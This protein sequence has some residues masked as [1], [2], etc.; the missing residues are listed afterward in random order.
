MNEVAVYYDNRTG[1]GLYYQLDDDDDS[2]FAFEEGVDGKLR[3]YSVLA[4][5]LI[6]VGIPRKLYYG[7]VRE[8]DPD[9]PQDDD[10]ILGLI[11]LD[12]DGEAENRSQSGGGILAARIGVA[13]LTPEEYLEVVQGEAKTITFIVEAKGRFLQAV[14]DEITVK[15]QDVKKVTQTV[16]DDQIERVTQELDIQVFRANI[17]AVQTAA[18]EPGLVIVEIAFD[19]QK[20]VLTHALKVLQEIPEA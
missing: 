1:L 11:P 6:A 17:T 4:D 12:W 19:N 20:T 2:C 15:L 14:A 3:R 13:Q 18:L 10:D 16:T 5:V 9:N 8:G 7:T